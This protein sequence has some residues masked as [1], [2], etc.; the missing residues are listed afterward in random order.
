MDRRCPRCGLRAL[1]D[2][3]ET[4]ACLLCA[5]VVREPTNPVGSRAWSIPSVPLRGVDRGRYFE[6]TEEAE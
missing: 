6:D 5:H 2:D 4:R 1:V 3:H